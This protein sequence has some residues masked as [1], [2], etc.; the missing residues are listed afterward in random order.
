LD[1]KAK[2]VLAEYW[3]NRTDDPGRPA[4]LDPVTHLKRLCLRQV[5]GRNRPTGGAEFV[6]VTSLLDQVGQRYPLWTARTPN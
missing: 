6:T 2:L 4:D 1:D 5:P 3:R